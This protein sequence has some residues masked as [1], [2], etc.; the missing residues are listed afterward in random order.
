MISTI[1]FDFANHLR[2]SEMAPNP[3]TQP[4]QSEPGRQVGPFQ[5]ERRGFKVFGHRRFGQGKPAETRLPSLGSIADPLLD[6]LPA[7]RLGR[8]QVDF[9]KAAVT[10]LPLPLGQRDGLRPSA[11]AAPQGLDWA[12]ASSS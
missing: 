12:Q 10:L 8:S 5:S 3:T 7:D 6:L 1:L 9:I 2:R 4:R 11:E